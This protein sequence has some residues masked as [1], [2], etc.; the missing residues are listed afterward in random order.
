LGDFTDSLRIRVQDGSPERIHAEERIKMRLMLFAAGVIAVIV[1]F[2]CWSM[3]VV[4]GSPGVEMQWVAGNFVAFLAG[5]LFGAAAC[6]GR[7]SAAP[8]AG[9]NR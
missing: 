1:W 2:A 8:S 4:P 3:T 7:I 9:D 5:G 6:F